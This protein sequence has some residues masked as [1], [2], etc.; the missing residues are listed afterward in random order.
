MTCPFQSSRLNH[1]NYIRWTIQTMKFLIAEP[2]SVP[3]C[4]L[5]SNTLHLRSSLNV[6]YHVSQPY[7]TP[8]KIRY[9]GEIYKCKID[10]TSIEIEYKPMSIFAWVR[11][12]HS[13]IRRLWISIKFNNNS[14]LSIIG[15]VINEK[16]VNLNQDPT[17]CRRRT[18]WFETLYVH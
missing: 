16:A 8:D 2:S 1:P 9:R 10:L 15:V 4:I 11:N 5:F 17:A 6:R 3:I 7:S 18:S 13:K 14:N 12:C